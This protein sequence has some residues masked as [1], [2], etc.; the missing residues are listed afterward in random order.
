MCGGWHS[1]PQEDGNKARTDSRTSEKQ[2]LPKT[3][4]YWIWEGSN[5]TPRETSAVSRRALHT[6]PSR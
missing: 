6:P 2:E 4:T 3:I 5:K 1:D